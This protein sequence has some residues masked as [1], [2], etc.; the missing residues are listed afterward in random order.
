MVDMCREKKT[1]VAEE[2]PTI[3]TGDCVCRNLCHIFMN[4]RDAKLSF[5]NNSIK[6]F[7][8]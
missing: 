1:G 8:F 3:Q 4:I 6:K 5:P 7:T 2:C